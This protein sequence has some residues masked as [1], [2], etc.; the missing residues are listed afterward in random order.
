MLNRLKQWAGAIKQDTASLYFAAQDS[1][2]PWFAKALAAFV[3]A[4]ALSPID[5][6]PDFVPVLGYLDDLLLLPAG[7]WLTISLIPDDVMEESRLRSASLREWPVSKNAAVIIVLIW[8]AAATMIGWLAYQ[9]F[10]G[11]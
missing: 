6:I 2:T 3:V 1:R 7:L 10:H 8:L 4:Y 9:T 11:Q 5:L